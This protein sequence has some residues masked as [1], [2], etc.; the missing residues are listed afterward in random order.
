M[1]LNE[2][3]PNLI[4]ISADLNE[5]RPDLKEI[6]Q[7]LSVKSSENRV[8]IF[9]CVVQS[10]RLKIGFSCSNPST[11]PPVSGFMGG[12]PPP[13]VTGVKSAGF[14]AGSARLGGLVGFR[15][16]LDTPA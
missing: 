3:R 7:D 16:C 5:I 13:T 1:D 10:S 2:I 9:R 15:G 11:N 14:R 4:E 6:Q 8:T 12:A